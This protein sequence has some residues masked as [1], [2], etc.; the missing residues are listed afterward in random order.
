MLWIHPQN[1]G[2]VGTELVLLHAGAV[3]HHS[4]RPPTPGG[5]RK[6]DYKSQHNLPQYSSSLSTEF[7]LATWQGFSS[8]Y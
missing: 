8:S 1:G 3:D 2:D 4:D 6:S 7:F 5:G